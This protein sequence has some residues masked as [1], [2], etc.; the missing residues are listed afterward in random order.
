MIS[1][2]SIEVYGSL[3]SL[4]GSA[5]DALFTKLTV[6]LSSKVAAWV[7]FHGVCIPL[8]PCV[9]FMDCFPGFTELSVFSCRPWSFLRQ[10]FR[11]LC[12]AIHG[13]PFLGGGEWKIMFLGVVTCPIFCVPC[14]LHLNKLSPPSVFMTGLGGQYPHQAA[15]SGIRRPSR[16]FLRVHALHTVCSLSEGVLYASP[17]RAGP[18]QA[19]RTF[20]CVP[21]SALKCPFVSSLPPCHHLQ[22]RGSSSTEAQATWRTGC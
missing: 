6:F 1:D 11:I 12:Q 20:C 13:S 16:P 10:R 14:C 3:L 18:G 7:S 9:W 8:E 21:Y 17:Q 19:L 5:V 15:Q 22:R 2:F 4:I